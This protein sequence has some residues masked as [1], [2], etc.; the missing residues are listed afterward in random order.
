MDSQ[1][2]VLRVNFANLQ[3]IVFTFFFC[4]AN[5]PHHGVPAIHL[6]GQH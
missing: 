2:I 3:K 6:K 1:K 5:R 4:F